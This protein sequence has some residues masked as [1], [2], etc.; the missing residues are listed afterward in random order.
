MMR[1]TA[2]VWS[3]SFD[4]A[5]VDELIVRGEFDGTAQELTAAVEGRGGLD[6]VR[7]VVGIASQHS[8]WSMSGG[9]VRADVFAEH[10]CDGEGF[11]SNDGHLTRSVFLPSGAV[12]AHTGIDR[13][14]DLPV[15]RFETVHDVL[16]G[17]VTVLNDCARRARTDLSNGALPMALKVVPIDEL[18]TAITEDEQI[19]HTVRAIVT[20]SPD[21]RV[22]QALQESWAGVEDRFS[23]IRD[24][25]IASAQ[26]TLLAGSGAA[27][28]VPVAD[29]EV[30]RLGIDVY[31]DRLTVSWPN[32][33]TS[34]VGQAD[35]ATADLYES[36][37]DALD[38]IEMATECPFHDSDH[39]DATA[40][41]CDAPTIADG[42]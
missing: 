39:R 1:S 8:V 5:A 31:G 36:V 40:C 18:W 33:S 6:V 21:E 37:C 42:E 4:R 19:Q 7:E 38:A 32:G 29:S 23:A 17:V 9:I 30:H 41:T 10:S 26:Q 13:L 15:V 25:L 11:L 14:N 34:T 20:A 2:G 27:G 35:P 24:E 22:A 28:C 16:D 3:L 12:L